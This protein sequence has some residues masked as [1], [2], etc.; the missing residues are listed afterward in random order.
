MRPQAIGNLLVT[1]RG[2]RLVN[3]QCEDR[4]M[5]KRK[6]IV[7]GGE[8]A[9]SLKSATELSAAP[10]DM[11]SELPAIESPPIS[12][13]SETPAVSSTESD[14]AAEPETAPGIAAPDSPA[15]PAVVR[16]QFKLNARRKRNALLAA[17]VVLAAGLGAVIGAAGS[18]SFAPAPRADVAGL[19]E[20]KAMEQSIAQ[21]STEITTL[22]A[23]IAAAN[24]AAQ[25]QIAKISDKIAERF[26]QAKSPETTGSIPTPRPAPG[27]QAVE[28][29]PARPPVVK[30]WAIR[31]ARG[32]LIYV[33]GH[34]DIYQVT[35][36]AH[37]PG[38]GPVQS[39]KRQDGHWVVATPKGII[40][41][42]R[43]R[44]Y[45]E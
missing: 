41:S 23:N 33:Q 10:S 6:K 45:F 15:S 40:V 11:K 34:G 27:V 43:D 25:G 19:Q 32:G 42:M 5:A 37:L 9:A 16:F 24:K 7:N 30:D 14:P 26:E 31:D 44:R 39:I 1:E 8:A 17:S 38:L 28:A 22:K 13:G 18:G 3:S 21:L 20:R 12:P 2:Y 36:G 4:P 35:P 29:P